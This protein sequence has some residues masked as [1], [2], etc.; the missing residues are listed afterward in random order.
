MDAELVRL[1]PTSMGNSILVL[2]LSCFFSH[3]I[4]ERDGILFAW[5]SYSGVLMAMTIHG[6]A[7]ST[8]HYLK[9]I[10]RDP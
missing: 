10:E 2:V 3:L 4:A 1:C 9:A 5:A 6:S 7:K 8:I